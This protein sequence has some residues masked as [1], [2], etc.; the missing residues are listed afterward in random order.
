MRVGC[1]RRRV[2][3][4]NVLGFL[5]GCTLCAP[6][7]LI[8]QENR[9][10]P[11]RT[12]VTIDVPFQPLNNDFSES[13]SF[14]DTVRKTENVTFAVDYASTRGALFDLG[15]GV[16]LTN[17]FGVGVTASRFQRASSASFD[18]MVPS[19]L[20]ANR[21]LDL[22]GSVSG[23]NRNEL[24]IHIQ[25]L[26]ALALRKN[27]RVILTG[28]P[29]IF[30]SKQDL[31]RSIEF[32]TLPGFTSLKLNQALLTEVERTVV[33]FNVGADITWPLAS[34][35]GVGTVARYSRAKVT[36][37]PGAESGVS[38]AIET[39]PGGLQIGGGIRLLF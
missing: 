30:N 25:A 23:L 6:G 28:G 3:R 31:V 16:R 21:P 13:L 38:R 35:L 20:V 8:A 32:E 24:G 37:D 2:M 5:L 33:G 12:F 22:A 14:A 19:P 36:L 39:H 29:S 1:H 27:A 18:L 10:W 9:A 26:Y 17:N 7:A 4:G 11:E 34:H 15:A